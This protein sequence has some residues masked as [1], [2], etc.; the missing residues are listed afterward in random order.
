MITLYQF[1]RV[2]GLPNASPFCMKIETYLRMAGLLYNTKF[3]NNPQQAPKGKLPYIDID[4]EKYADSEFIID[5]LK[6]RYGD[7]LDQNLTE[8]QQVLSMLIDNVFCE[9]FYWLCVYMRWQ[10]EANWTQVNKD[11]FGRLPMLLKLFL[12]SMIRRKTL[13]SLYHQGIG[14]HSLEEV[15]IMGQK[16]FDS[17]ASLLGS[18]PYFLGDTPSSIDA[19]AFS[20]IAN[21]LMGPL[22]DPL[23]QHGMKIPHLITYCDR[24]WDEFYSDFEKPNHWLMQSN[25]K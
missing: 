23:K 2:W 8:E 19:T 3:I 22:N 6:S 21:I 4:G 14:R 13:K 10:Y 1:Y 7:I 25:N 24:M 11:Y 15:V 16:S 20:F 9:R 18:K 17:M 5:E 12:P